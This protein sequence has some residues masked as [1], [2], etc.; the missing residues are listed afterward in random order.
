MEA[1]SRAIPKTSPLLIPALRTAAE[2]ANRTCTLAGWAVPPAA[3]TH[4]GE[5]PTRAAEGV[6]TAAVRPA[7]AAVPPGSEAVEVPAVGRST[8][9]VR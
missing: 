3:A 7:A 8:A 2:A 5:V 6:F 9:G 1:S 4:T